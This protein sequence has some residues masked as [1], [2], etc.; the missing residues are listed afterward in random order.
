MPLPQHLNGSSSMS[1]IDPP[2]PGTTYL[3]PSRHTAF[4]DRYQKQHSQT[5]AWLER[6]TRQAAVIRDMERT[7]EQSW[8]TEKR[9]LLAQYSGFDQALSTVKQVELTPTTGGAAAYQVETEAGLCY[10][11]LAWTP[12]GALRGTIVLAGHKGATAHLIAHYV[13][14]GLRVLLPCL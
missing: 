5:L 4:Y 3:S 2:L 13:T 7:S 9:R 10:T 14:Q 1:E 6:A 12:A 8:L 11:G